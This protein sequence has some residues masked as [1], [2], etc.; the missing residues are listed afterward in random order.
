[1]NALLEIGTEHLPSRFVEPA[2][3]QMETLGAKLLEEHR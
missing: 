3:K 2:L 1:M